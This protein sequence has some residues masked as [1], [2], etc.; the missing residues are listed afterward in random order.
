M[1]HLVQIYFGNLHGQ[2]DLNDSSLF[3]IHN[4]R[5]SKHSVNDL[6]SGLSFTTSAITSCTVCAAQATLRTDSPS[7]LGRLNGWFPLIAQTRFGALS[8][9]IPDI[10]ILNLLQSK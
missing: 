6:K 10:F 1:F 7:K 8:D 5:D 2:I 4:T 3:P 9:T